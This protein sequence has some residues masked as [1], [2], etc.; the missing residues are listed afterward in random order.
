LPICR[1]FRQQSTLSPVCTGLHASPC[2][3]M[4]TTLSKDVCLSVCPC[5]CLS[6]NAVHCVS[7]NVPSLTGC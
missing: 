7:K 4:R 6:V 1:R 2:I 3:I 5:I